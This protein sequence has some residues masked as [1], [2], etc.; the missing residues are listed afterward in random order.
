MIHNRIIDD[1]YTQPIKLIN[2]NMPAWQTSKIKIQQAIA[3]FS[4]IQLIS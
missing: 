4:F 3:P 1:L 2:M